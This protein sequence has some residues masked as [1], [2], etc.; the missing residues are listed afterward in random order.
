MYK[1]AKNFLVYTCFDL[2]WCTRYSN[3]S[4]CNNYSLIF[5]DINF[6]ACLVN[7]RFS[8]NRVHGS[9]AYPQSHSYWQ[10][11]CIHFPVSTATPLCISYWPVYTSTRVLVHVHVS[12]ESLIKNYF[13][14]KIGSKHSFSCSNT[15][16]SYILTIFI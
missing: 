10:A 2:F 8:C 14:W 15:G 12:L 16:F 1:S 3:W 4:P 7:S 11:P 5:L 6:K 9:I 13:L